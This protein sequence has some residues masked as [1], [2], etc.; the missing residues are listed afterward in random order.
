LHWLLGSGLY[1]LSPTRKLPTIY[2]EPGSI[3]TKKNSPD[4]C[5]PQVLG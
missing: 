1:I 5:P 4:D 3:S 2:N